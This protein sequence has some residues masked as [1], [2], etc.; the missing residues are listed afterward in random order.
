[1]KS[2]PLPANEVCRLQSLRLY[3]ILDTP[4][5]TGFDNITRL[6]ALICEAPIALVSL[7]DEHRQWFKARVGLMVAETSRDLAFCAHAIL[8]SDLFV[9]PDT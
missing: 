4:P 1:M 5:A 2:A 3:Q 9:V 7:V 8:Q 6:A